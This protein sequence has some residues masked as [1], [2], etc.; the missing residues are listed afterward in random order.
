M[1]ITLQNIKALY[2][3]VTKN[4]HASVMLVD[5]GF[6]LK[7]EQKNEAGHRNNFQ[8]EGAVKTINYLIA[9]IPKFI[10]KRSATSLLKKSYPINSYAAKHVLER[11]SKD[12]CG[13]S[14]NGQFIFA[15]LLLGYDLDPK[16]FNQTTNEVDINAQFCGN[17]RD[18]SKTACPCGGVY[19]PHAIKQHERGELHT[20]YM[21]SKE[22][23]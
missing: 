8:Y 12:N 3:E 17:Y 5:C 6:I 9:E 18:L 16:Y 10:L 22:N 20:L 2:D 4:L 14:S 13:Y 11:N 7:S 19:T 23:N 1:Q 21:K 15:M